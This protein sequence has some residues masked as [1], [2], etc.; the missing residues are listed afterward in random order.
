MTCMTKIERLC[1][2]CAKK[3]ASALL[4]RLRGS[5]DLHALARACTARAEELDR[6]GDG[7]AAAQLREAAR[8]LVQ[9]AAYRG[10]PYPL[11]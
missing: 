9:Y 5:E 10:L 4:R 8:S 1:A 6:A 3:G 2:L 11:D 7:A